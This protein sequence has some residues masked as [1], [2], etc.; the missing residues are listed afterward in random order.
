MA[1]LAAIGRA[2]A[3]GSA[4]AALFLTHGCVDAATMWPWARRRYAEVVGRRR[5]EAER[6]AA[7]FGVTVAGW[8]PRPARHL[9]RELDAAEREIRVAIAAIGADQLWVPAFEGGNPDHD[10]VSA[11]A[12]RFAAEGL[13]VLE[14]AEYNLAGGK[15]NSHRFPRP[16]G[17]R[18]DAG[19]HPRRAG[20]Q[21]P[22]ARPLRLGA[23]QPRLCRDRAGGVP[24]PRRLRLRRPA[25]RRKAL[26][27]ALPV[28]P[29]PPSWRRF[30]PP[31]PR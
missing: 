4:V 23:G 5:A 12:S 25:T 29:V 26:V 27:R 11:I 8:S 14:F 28:G 16:N 1:C 15:V 21:A 9:W 19:A 20:R 18:D 6:V 7:E 30:H 31:E 17:D 13:S 2:R 10:G 3:A 24:S 22:R